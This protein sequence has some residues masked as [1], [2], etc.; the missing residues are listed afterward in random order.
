MTTKAPQ[1]ITSTPTIS[2]GYYTVTRDGQV[3]PAYGDAVRVVLRIW[4]PSS[5]DSASLPPHLQFKS[6]V[7]LGGELLHP[8]WGDYD[9]V[10]D[11][12]YTVNTY[13]AATWQAAF[14]AATQ[15]ATM[16]LQKLDDALAQR[17]K[18]LSDAEN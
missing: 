3:D 7:N 6:R 2:G 9:A 10:L 12:R 15:Y 16:E 8:Y 13:E 17:A 11:A 5:E 18:A 1:S 14:D 4:L